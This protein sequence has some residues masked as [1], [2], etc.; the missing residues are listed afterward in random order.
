MIPN[1]DVLMHVCV[2]AENKLAVTL[3]LLL[4]LQRDTFE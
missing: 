2:Q 4:S 1:K 3:L